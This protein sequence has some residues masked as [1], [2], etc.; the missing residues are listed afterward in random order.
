MFFQQV[1]RLFHH[2]KI[3][4]STHAKVQKATAY[5]IIYEFQKSSRAVLTI[6]AI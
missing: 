4:R 2:L 3:I 6:R 1:K 5:T